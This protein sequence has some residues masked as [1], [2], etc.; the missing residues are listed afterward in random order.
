LLGSLCLKNEK[1]NE[2]SASFFLFFD[3]ILH[4]SHYF[5]IGNSNMSK[6][7]FIH[8]MTLDHSINCQHHV[9]IQYT[10][11]YI[12]CLPFLVFDQKS[13]YNEQDFLRPFYFFVWNDIPK[14]MKIATPVFPKISDNFFHFDATICKRCSM[15][16]QLVKDLENYEVSTG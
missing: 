12:F 1:T 14:Q 15:L 13:F 10:S 5:A 7:F 8:L 9:A 4:Y 11:P 2:K 16:P 3:F 6:S